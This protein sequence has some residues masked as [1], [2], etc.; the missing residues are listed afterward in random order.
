M[1]FTFILFLQPIAEL[2]EGAVRTYWTTTTRGRGLSRGRSSSVG[3][4][5]GTMGGG[6]GGGPGQQCCSMWPSY[7]VR[8]CL[9]LGCAG[10]GV[11]I[12]SFGLVT[13]LVG[14]VTNTIVGL[15]LPPAIYIQLARR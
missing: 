1:L 9:V 15:I 5:I 8:A 4:T 12:P 2:A 10:L 3:D 13:N 6:Q 14:A 11:S 7:L